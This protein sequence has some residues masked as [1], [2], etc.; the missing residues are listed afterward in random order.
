MSSEPNVIDFPARTPIDDVVENARRRG[1]AEE[2]LRIA[3][4]LHDVVAYRFATIKMQAGLALRFLDDAPA[5]LSESLRA[6]DVASKEALVELGE[7]LGQLRGAADG[8]SA[9]G[10]SDLVGLAAKLTAAGVRTQVVVKGTVRPLPPAVDLTVFRIAQESLSNV[11]RHAGHT[12][13]VVTLTY[14]PDCVAVVVENEE[15]YER[16]GRPGASKT[17]A[18]GHGI[19][20]MHERVAEVGGR[21]AAGRRPQGGFVV[22]ALL[23][24]FVR[25]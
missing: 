23:P 18:S 17:R 19:E 14:E 4:E 11:L 12:T 20:G 3:R 5:P 13:A 10:A 7:I 9:H 15:G 8:S 21:L 6:I 2:R 25:R 1:A 16:E 22:C 24:L